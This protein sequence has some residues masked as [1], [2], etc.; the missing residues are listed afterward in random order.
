MRGKRKHTKREAHEQ[1]NKEKYLLVTMTGEPYQLVRIHYEVFNR[2]KVA[3]IFSRLECMDYDPDHE[4]WVWLYDG[5]AKNLQFNRSYASIPEEKHPIV[6]G[7]FFSRSEHEMFLNV[8]SFDRATKGIAFFDRYFR[9]TLIKKASAKVTDIEVVNK[10]FEPSAADGVPKHEDYFDKRPVSKTD[11][12]A[13]VKKLSMIASS[14]E[15]KTEGAMLAFSYLEESAKQPFPEI[16]RFPTNFHE[17]GIKG[18]EASLR[19]REAIARQHWSGNTGYT[20]Y[21]L[22]Q[23]ML[24]GPTSAASHGTGDP[25][26]D[27]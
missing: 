7:A 20:F 5:E 14:V 1:N 21:D 3:R 17:D 4:R 19:T 8:N 23:D 13:V 24:H 6:I 15:D 27:E 22:V 11:P 2:G 18:I 25:D 12:A 9:R 26:A 16:E 10:F